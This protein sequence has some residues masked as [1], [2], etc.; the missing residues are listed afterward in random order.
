MN[1][2]LLVPCAAAL[3]TLTACFASI[4]E[5]DTPSD[6]LTGFWVSEGAEDLGN[7]TFGTRELAINDGVWDMLFTLYTDKELTKPVFTTEFQGTYELQGAS[8]SLLPGARNAVFRFSHK[9]LTP[10]TDDAGVLAEMAMDTCGLVTNEES[11]ISET[12]CSFIPSVKTCGQEYDIVKVESGK[13][14]LGERP[15]DNNLCTE[16]RRPAVFG[17]PLMQSAT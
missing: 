4:P 17:V 2:R 7:G 16:D 10:L 14:W 9:F 13:L 1:K 15:V 8:S 5:T 11:D 6:G 3:L 12:G